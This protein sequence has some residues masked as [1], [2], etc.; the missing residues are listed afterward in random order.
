MSIANPQDPELDRMLWSDAGMDAYATLEAELCHCEALC[1]C[2][3]NDPANLTM[4]QMERIFG[5]NPNKPE[6]TPQ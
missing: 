4:T 5:W 6:D 3:W 1:T 2:H